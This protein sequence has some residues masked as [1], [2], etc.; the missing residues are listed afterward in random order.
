MFPTIHIWQIRCSTIESQSC[1]L[2]FT[3][4]I[5]WFQQDRHL[6]TSCLCPSDTDCGFSLYKINCCSQGMQRDFL[7][8]LNGYWG[9]VHEMT[10]AHYVLSFPFLIVFFPS[11]F[12]LY[13][14]Q[15]PPHL[16]Y[17][18]HI[19]HFS[20]PSTHSQISKHLKLPS[21]SPFV[22]NF[23]VTFPTLCN[24]QVFRVFLM[25]I[26][27]S[28]RQE[29]KTFHYISNRIFSS[30]YLNDSWQVLIHKDEEEICSWGSL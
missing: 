12:F 3:Y 4:I 17:P 2:L 23:L 10:C 1:I 21:I 9:S 18:C 8:P 14:A 16:L 5:I 15:V 29:S 22:T 6:E 28:W 24:M 19:P 26:R 30:F 11:L 7:C 20:P 13:P 25:I 27:T